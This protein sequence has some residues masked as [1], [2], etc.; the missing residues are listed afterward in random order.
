M[1]KALL[2]IYIFIDEEQSDDAFNPILAQP[3]CAFFLVY[4]VKC[5]CYKFQDCP[6]WENHSTSNDQIKNMQQDLGEK[7]KQK[8]N[9]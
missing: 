1:Q 6:L 4:S 8:E 3:D 9:K 2:N 7:K 5:T